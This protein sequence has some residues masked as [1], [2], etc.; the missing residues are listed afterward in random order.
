MKLI[1]QN[2]LNVYKIM[3]ETNDPIEIENP[4]GTVSVG[5]YDGNNPYRI[6]NTIPTYQ[7][8]AV[9][10]VITTGNVVNINHNIV[11]N[12][13]LVKYAC[14][15][16]FIAY[17]YIVKYCILLVN[18]NLIGWLVLYPILQILAAS[19]GLIGSLNFKRSYFFWFVIGVFASIIVQ[20]LIMSLKINSMVDLKIINFFLDIF[21]LFYIIKFYFILPYYNSN[22][23]CIKKILNCRRS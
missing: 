12:A 20:A 7:H 8:N 13:I 6:H 11:R 21:F 23:S 1:T 16:K 5:L 2:K 17:I 22:I 18:M 14:Y 4:N 3:T 10:I 19:S 15:I 9:D